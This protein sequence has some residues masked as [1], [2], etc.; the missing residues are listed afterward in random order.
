MNPI[1]KLQLTLPYLSESESESLYSA[2]TCTLYPSLFVWSFVEKTT[3]FEQEEQEE[4]EE[5]GL[6]VLQYDW[7]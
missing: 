6:G 7:N 3:A 5:D 2:P 4:Q 1:R